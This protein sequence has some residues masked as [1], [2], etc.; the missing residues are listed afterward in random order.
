MRHPCGLRGDVLPVTLGRGPVCLGRDSS[1]S[2]PSRGDEGERVGAEMRPGALPGEPC[3]VK[4]GE[5]TGG[6]V[7][8]G[9]WVGFR[10]TKRAVVRAEKIYRRRQLDCF[11]DNALARSLVARIRAV[12]R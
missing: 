1:E 7:S 9:E 8:A 3:R 11:A 10:V 6:G 4:G 5:G 12:T 2:P